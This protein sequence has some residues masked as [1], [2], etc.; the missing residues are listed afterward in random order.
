[1]WSGRAT[2]TESITA[3]SNTKGFMCSTAK[4]PCSHIVSKGE[5]FISI[6]WYYNVCSWKYINLWKPVDLRF[7]DGE[8]HSFALQTS[9]MH[10]CSANMWYESSNQE[11][12]F[13]VMT[14][15]LIYIV[16]LIYTVYR[17]NVW[18]I[19][20][21]M[22]DMFILDLVEDANRSSVSQT[23]ATKVQTLFTISVSQTINT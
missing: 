8:W 2:S 15:V 4:S 7:H 14:L 16:P 17:T 12:F 9:G 3:A 1:M 6:H 18:Y 5:N 21:Y 22:L 20:M 19:C 13:T 23:S 10:R 11:F